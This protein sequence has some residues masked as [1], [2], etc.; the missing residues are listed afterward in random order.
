MTSISKEQK[1]TGL[2]RY[3]WRW[4]FFAGLFFTP[5]L[6][7]LSVTG[8]IYLFKPYIEPAMH[9]DLYYVHSHHHAELSATKQL[10]SVKVKYP[11]ASLT[12]FTDPKGETRASEVHISLNG[13][14]YLV[15]VNPYTAEVIGKL[16]SDKMLMQQIINLHG[17]IM[18]GDNTWGDWLIELSACW[19]VILLLTGLYLY[20]PR[21]KQ[22]WLSV[23]RVRWKSGSRTR[24]RDLHA[25]TAFW[26]TLVILMLVV[27]GLPWAGFFGKQL[28]RVVQWTNTAYYD[29][30]PWDGSVQSDLKMKDVAK[31]AWA[32]EKLPVPE[33]V[34]SNKGMLNIESI[35]EVARKENIHEG[36]TITFPWDKT[37]VY[38]I[39]TWGWPAESYKNYAT[40]GVDQYTGDVLSSIRWSDYSPLVKTVETGIALHEGRL[41]GWPNLILNATACLTLVFIAVSG[42]MMWW[43]RRPEKQ[44]GVPAKF[45]GYRL[46]V[47]V[48]VL[49]LI[50]SILMPLAGISIAV[51]F[52]LDQLIRLIRR[53]VVS[54]RA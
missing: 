52:M 50:L 18:A 49:T 7:L 47:G 12:D 8:L 39:S 9:K 15:F 36:Y 43:K 2:Y 38:V 28:D 34:Y 37:G 33:S 24:W 29:W 48:I 32:A 40:L 51:V 3:V 11:D 45:E 44:F 4:H 21:N 19:A 17:S 6:I 1:T 35:I 27:T 20:W 46:S 25:F 14:N 54:R 42:I 10:E 26:M 22:S 5:L 13:A 31:T 30:A 41:F 53:L 16:D 23:L